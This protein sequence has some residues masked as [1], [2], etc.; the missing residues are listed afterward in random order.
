MAYGYR[1]EGEVKVRLEKQVKGKTWGHDEAGKWR[2]TDLGACGMGG[3]VTYVTRWEEERRK[4]KKIAAQQEPAGVGAADPGWQKARALYP[5]AQQESA[6][7][8]E[9]A[10]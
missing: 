6:G 3:E 1:Q 10:M 2:G 9:V 7:E 5:V 8:W 4:R